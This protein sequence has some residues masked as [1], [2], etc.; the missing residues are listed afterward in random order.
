ME[1]VSDENDPKTIE[2]LALT[3]PDWNGATIT[4]GPNSGPAI[5]VSSARVRAMS[6]DILASLNIL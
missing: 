5:Q 2:P 1:D 6:E 3:D 4:P